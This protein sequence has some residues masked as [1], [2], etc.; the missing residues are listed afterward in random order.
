MPAD[1]PENV[2]NTAVKG[3]IVAPM[4][5]ASGAAATRL[6]AIRLLGPVDVRVGGSP[7]KVDTR[8]AVALL[9][10]LAVT[11]RTSSRDAI[12][13]LLWP[14]S[15]DAEARGALRRTLSVLNA[16]LGG[17]GLSIDRSSVALDPSMVDVDVARFRASIAIARGHGHP[18]EQPCPICR[19]ALQEAVALDRGPFM[20][21]FGLR[22]S[23]AFDEWLAAEREAYQREL[24]GALER[25]VREQLASGGW[26]GAIAA[27]RRWQEI[28]PLHEPA[29]RSLMEAYA[30]SGETAAAVRQYRDAA[31]LLDR[32]LGVTPLPE[33][34]ELYEAILAGSLT[35]I[36]AAPPGPTALVVDEG[37]ITPPLIGRD[38]ELS[39]I[40]A[41]VGDSLSHG[42]LIVVEGEAGV[43]KTRLGDAVME[44]AQQAGHL[45]IAARCY[46]GETTIA[47]GPIVAL[48]R[49]R[50]DTV[51]GAS[52]AEWLSPR[53]RATLATLVPELEPGPALSP[54]REPGP[55]AQLALLEAITEGLVGPARHPGSPA[56]ATVVRVDDL[57]W[58]DDAT[59]EVLAFLARRLDRHPVALLLSWRREDLDVRAS[60]LVSLAE[61]LPG[62]LVHLERLAPPDIHMLVDALV[63]QRR[64][65]PEPA[66]L[67]ELVD[68]A[69]G[70]P[71]YVVEALAAGDRRPGTMPAGI[72]ALL[73]ARLGALGGVASQ[74]VGAAAVIG[75][76]FDGDIV[77]HISGRSEEETVLGLEELTRRGI[78]HETGADGNVEYDFAHARLRDVAYETTSVARRRLLHRRAAEAY[79]V[80]AGRDVD[81]LGRLARIARHE[82]EA[83][84]PAEAAEAFR[85]AG[86]LA[87]L[88]YA[89]REG[90]RYLEA[91][92]ALGHPDAVGIHESIGDLRTRIGDYAGA[93]AALDT[94]AATAP[95]ERLAG[96]EHRIG[97]IHLRRGDPTAAEAHLRAALGALEEAAS[98]DGQATRSRIQADRA[99]AAARAGRLDDAVGLAADARAAAT[100]DASAEAEAD[101][102]SGLLAR[103][104]GDLDAAWVA[105]ER[106]L[107]VAT[108]LADPVPA[109]AAQNALALV[110]IDAGDLE[111]AI[112]L[113]ESA[114]VTARQ[115][116]ERH[117][118]AALENNIAD[119]LE[120]A[121]RRDEAM[122]HLK[123]AAA[124]FTEVGGSTGELEPG[125]WM[126]ESW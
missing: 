82:R 93:I 124:A 118:E 81:Q 54:A 106:S 32:E 16:G 126:L 62:V 51:V 66:I 52:A 8:K 6:L 36:P 10:Y 84:R 98:N 86:E 49:A 23:D 107:S 63:A 29:H 112:A 46:A 28:D 105:L 56:S 69:E 45:V 24:A 35:A 122:E 111:R 22:D 72:R 55:A 75:R 110:A 3:G 9:A 96:I 73:Q 31:A 99:I 67:D 43:G 123:A 53:T 64:P 100:G 41:A 119:A 7:L 42:R 113:A 95:P 85:Q 120:A 13:A 83:G 14:E 37:P 94:A 76:S 59:L 92:L 50:L 103:D 91:A 33:T 34:T 117:L 20:D 27:G 25:L 60:A 4:G 5:S 74:V 88:V 30:R 79:R 114:L 11:G 18:S 70:L 101:R 87:R 40:L 115:T 2:T 90:L 57:Q 89:N 12:A 116:G 80:Q 58:A 121:G 97:R 68:E 21:G 19:A 15:D 61:R 48:L 102:I 17:V 26:D 77:R 44:V 1:S 39:Q 104:Q 65:A 108:G 109:V 47:L 78:V 38:A 125:I 71:L